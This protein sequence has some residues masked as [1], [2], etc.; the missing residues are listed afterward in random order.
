LVKSF[1]FIYIKGISTMKKAH[2]RSKKI[3]CFVSLLFL[4]LV[5]GQSCVSLGLESPV[6]QTIPIEARFSDGLAYKIDLIMGDGKSSSAS[7]SSLGQLPNPAR[8]LAITY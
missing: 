3:L 7:D 4:T 1:K 6:A 8:A 2:A 5:G